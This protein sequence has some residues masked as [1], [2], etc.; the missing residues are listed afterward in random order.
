[1]AHRMIQTKE[2]WHRKVTQ[3]KGHTV[4]YGIFD[5]V[6]PVGDNTT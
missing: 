1:M 5:T 2:Q 6:S 4:L 3:K